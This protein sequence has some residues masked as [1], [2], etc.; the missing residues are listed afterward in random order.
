[1]QKWSGEH[2]H[3]GGGGVGWYP[4]DE[5]GGNAQ[6]SNQSRCKSDPSG[7][8]KALFDGPPPGRWRNMSYVIK[9]LGT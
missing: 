4:H 7:H 5:R 9:M 6:N 1:M 3:D 2:R 8:D